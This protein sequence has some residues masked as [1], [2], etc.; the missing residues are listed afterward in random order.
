[1]PTIELTAEILMISRYCEIITQILYINKALSLVKLVIFSYI[2]KN[3]D[4]CT[5]TSKDSN[6][7]TYKCLSMISGKFHLFL[8]N[9]PI[10]IKALNILNKNNRIKIEKNIVYPMHSVFALNQIYEENSFIYKAI[11]DSKNIPDKYFLK[12]VVSNV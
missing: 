4:L 1:M 10:I 8:D 2:V 6:E 12:E 11:K 7:V 5:Y 9:L 3:I